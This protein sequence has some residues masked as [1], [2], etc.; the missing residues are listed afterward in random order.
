MHPFRARRGVSRAHPLDERRPRRGPADLR[1]RRVRAHRKRAARL[2]G[3]G[4]GRSELDAAALTASSSAPTEHADVTQEPECD[5]EK[6]ESAEPAEF[7]LRDRKSDGRPRQ[8][9]EPEEWPYEG[10]EGAAHVVR[11]HPQE[12][13]DEAWPDE[14]EERQNAAHR[15]RMVSQPQP[16]A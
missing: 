11:E 8:E 15:S 9:D 1:A 16:L 10:V 2:I 6:P 14:G 12:E 3:Q 13:D 7:V 5:D 4:R